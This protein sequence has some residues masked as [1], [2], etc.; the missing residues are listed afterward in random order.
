MNTVESDFYRGWYAKEL[1]AALPSKPNF[2][3]EWSFQTF[4]ARRNMVR[5]PDDIRLTNDKDIRAEWILGDDSKLFLEFCA[6]GDEQLVAFVSEE[7]YPV[8]P[9]L[10]SGGGH[11][12]NM[13]IR[14]GEGLTT[15]DLKETINMTAVEIKDFLVK[16]VETV[17]KS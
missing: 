1:L 16:S 17:H 10:R 12:L 8:Q 7:P 2:G 6:N 3:S 9:S 14:K 4:M 11:R 15:D 13:A 5:E